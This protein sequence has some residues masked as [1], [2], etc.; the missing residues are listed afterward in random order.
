MTQELFKE[1]YIPWRETRKSD[2]LVLLRYAERTLGEL[3]SLE[4]FSERME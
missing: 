3:D 2:K 1:D 4:A